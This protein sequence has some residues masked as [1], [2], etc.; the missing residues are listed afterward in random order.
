[1]L[2]RFLLSWLGCA[3][4]LG[5]AG[6]GLIDPVGSA[7]K[8]LQNPDATVRRDAIEKLR[9]RRDARSVEPLIAC[10]GDGDMDVRAAAAAA[11]GEFNDDRAIVPLI[12]C[13][14]VDYT[15]LRKATMASLGKLNHAKVGEQLIAQLQNKGADP[16]MTL[17]VIETL[18]MLRESRAVDALLSCLANDSDQISG[19]AI[20]ALGQI[21]APAVTPLVAALKDP[22][23]R[24]R[25][26]AAEAL[27]QIGD[28]RAV[29]PLVACL[30]NPRPDQTTVGEPDTP[31]GEES[32]DQ[33]KAHEEEDSQVRKKTGEALGKLGQPAVTPLI[34]CLDD[35][36]PSVRSLAATA[37][38]QLHDSRA[39]APL[40]DHLMKLSGKDTTDEENSEDVNV[41]ESLIDALADL[42]TPAIKPLLACLKDKDIHGQEDAA[43]VLNRL[44]YLPADAEGKAAFFV[45]LRSWD[46]LVELGAPAVAPLL[47]CLKDE[48]Y[49]RRQG[50][51]QALGQLGDKRAVKPLIACLQDE[52]VDVK[53]NAATALGQL[54]DKSAV[55]PLIKAFTNEDK[56]T[57]L[58][59]AEALGSL[60]DPAAVAPLAASLTDQDAE[61]RRTC[62]QA[63]D[64]LHYQP[65]QVADNV[66]YLIAL[67][68]WDK[69]A[70]LGAPA[71]DPLSACLS[72]QSPD[73]RQGAVEALGDL[74][75]K[76][77]I[78]PLN[79]ALP[80][81]DLNASLV[82]ALE[83]LGWKPATE[84]QQVY[85]W[86]GKKD[87]AHLKQE[88]EKTREVLL[89]DVGSGDRRKVQDAVFTFMAL[90]NPK[91]VDD[92]VQILDDH[93]DQ[94]LAETYLNCGNDK[95]AQAAHDWAS[96]NGYTITTIPS[97]NAHMNWG[98]W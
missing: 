83:R 74:G 70:K 47:D 92:L 95:L 96:Q 26:L 35:N 64:K 87:S 75:D 37:L 4:L 43:A 46:K 97:D 82:S 14:P 40:I 30:K 24:V 34:A 98:S 33:K 1:M 13:L 69:V 29:G 77:A 65:P 84:S 6:C 56:E 80:D 27:G 94:E 19:E 11:L 23:A 42:G 5:L 49:S 32:D 17:G 66:T 21:G 52:N 88:W 12:A 79:E 86:I 63:L 51:A 81:W 45:L 61:I 39:I 7:I 41:H 16:A 54:G 62:A 72:D 67:Q 36:D 44:Q 78:G 93:G 59:A 53:K 91:I 85:A 90:G 68:A 89:N 8:K 48:D 20:D 3:L 9:L 50:A 57:K 71:F 28:A 15:G 73:I 22:K 76:R 10:L 58:A 60:A 18:G 55:E 38:G 31:N 2:P 25:G